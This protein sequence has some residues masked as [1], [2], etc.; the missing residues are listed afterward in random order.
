MMAPVRRVRMFAGPNGSGKSTII[1]EFE[2]AYGPE[3]VGVY[4]N[5][6]EIEEA[7]KQPDGLDLAPFGVENRGEE[8]EAFVAA[9]TWPMERT[10]PVPVPPAE[11]RGGR[12]R[13]PD[14]E[15][16][17][18]LSAVVADYLRIALIAAYV[19]FT[20][21]TVMSSAGKLD[22]LREARAAGFK[23]YLYFVTTDD[24]L[25]NVTRVQNRVARGGHPVSEEAIR[26]RYRQSL[27]NLP[28]AARLADQTYL[29]DNSTEGDGLTALPIAQIEDGI[30]EILVDEAPRWFTT[31]FPAARPDA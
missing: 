20:F 28:A 31:A 5:A 3:R 23:T 8:I 26:R 21:E 11:V 18:Y 17:S 24:P 25:I 16:N 10:P 1:Q 2:A 13:F 7:L 19:P 6:D 4:V 9:T 12:L 22:V 29:F 15:I 27:A 14:A 30:L